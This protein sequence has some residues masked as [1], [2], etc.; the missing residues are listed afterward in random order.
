MNRRLFFQKTRRIK[1]FPFSQ[2][3]K[4][5]STQALKG[6]VISI[7]LAYARMCFSVYTQISSKLFAAVVKRNSGF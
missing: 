1:P 4:D 3:P 6:S 2:T 7:C 5:A